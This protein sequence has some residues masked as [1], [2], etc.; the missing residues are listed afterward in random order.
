MFATYNRDSTSTMTMIDPR[1]S[2]VN[3]TV[4]EGA[5]SAAP[6]RGAFSKNNNWAA[7][8]TYLGDLGYFGR[9]FVDVIETQTAQNATYGV[10]TLSGNQ[11][12]TAD[13]TYILTDRVYVPNGVTLTIEPGTKIYSTFDN[14]NTTTGSDATNDD[15]VG[16]LIIA[17]GGKI[18]AQGTETA[19]IVFDAL[20]SLEAELGVD[21]PYDPDTIA[22][23]APSGNYRSMGWCDHSWKRVHLACGCRAS[24]CS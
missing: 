2:S 4:T 6:Y 17:R 24:A 13:K 10:D 20:Q 19:P 18:M 12:W 3:A 15:S 22:G 23:P 21:L 8:W 7:G 5:P 9:I 11:I 14:K 1:P 16:V